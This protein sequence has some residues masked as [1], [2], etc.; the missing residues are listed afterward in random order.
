MDDGRSTIRLVLNLVDHQEEAASCRRGAGAE[1]LTG[2]EGGAAV[3]R[4]RR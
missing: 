1:V 4:D 2:E 3:R